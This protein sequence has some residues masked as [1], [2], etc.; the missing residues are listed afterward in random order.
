MGLKD[1][2]AVMRKKRSQSAANSPAHVYTRRA[3]ICPTCLS[4]ILLVGAIIRGLYLVELSGFPETTAPALDAAFHDHW[5]RALISGDWSSPEFFADPLIHTTPYFRPPAYAYFLGAVYAVTGGSPL[6]AR[7]VQM[8]LGLVNVVLGFCLG[9]ALFGPSIGLLVAAVL[10]CYWT[11]PYFEGELLAPVLLVTLMLSS[12]LVWLRWWHRG[13]WLTSTSAGLLLGVFALARPNALALA[14]VVWL[15]S[16]WVARRKREPGRLRAAL[17]GLPL[18]V[19][20]AIAPATI[21]NYAVAGEFVPITAN[22][23]VN[24]YIGNNERA[25]G[26][27]ARIPIL[28][29]LTG[30]P[31]WTCFDQPAI[32]RGVERLQQRR[33]TASE[34]SSFFTDRAFEFIAADPGAALTLAAKKACL[35]WGPAEISN[36]RQLAIARDTS[37]VLRWLPTFPLVLSL[38]ILG[39][40]LLARELR[41]RP[42]DYR[43]DLSVLLAA[44]VLVYFASHLPFFVAGRYRVPLL[45]LLALFAAVGIHR[46]VG[47]VRSGNRRTAAAWSLVWVALLVG[48]HAR[49]VDYQPDRGRWHFQLS[50]AYRMNGDIDQQINELRLAIEHG[51]RSDPL[52]HNNLGV[53]L[54]GRGRISDAIAHIQQALRIDPQYLDA[55]ANLGLAYAN[56][57]RDPDVPFQFMKRPEK[58]GNGYRPNHS[59]EAHMDPV[60]I[61]S[62]VGNTASS[63]LIMSPWHP[64]FMAKF[65]NPPKR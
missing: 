49:L 16:L 12:A 44:V 15:W 37:L 57:G 11:F 59:S 22:V 7:T 20:V 41:R 28:Q 50:E 53:V 54:L 43:S 10:S 35:F 27:T 64:T 46:L 47:F 51:R 18:G 8:L 25:D 48:A 55:H 24:L 52:P 5:A 61:V 14:P 45:P 30:L 40:C 36:N 2:I 31:G 17:L 1:N 34:V 38:A 42:R 19:A 21:R 65:P 63:P 39:A 56:S 26:Y 6:G 3:F 9:R 33:L 23:G 13:G 32:S 4:T 29:S 62:P 58:S 60:L